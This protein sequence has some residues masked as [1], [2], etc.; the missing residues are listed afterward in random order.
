VIT[1]VSDE[2]KIGLAEKLGASHVINRTTQDIATEIMNITGNGVDAVIDHVGASTWMT[3]LK[4]LK[5]GG[6]MAVCGATSG[7]VANIEVR[8]VYNKQAWI[9][10][11]YL[12]TK[13][14]LGEMMRFMQTK[15]IRPVIDSKIDLRMTARAH[16][17]M[18][19]NMHFGKIVLT[20]H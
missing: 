12:G 1:T 5:L 6:K 14:E 9:I 17:R 19:N 2:A 16:E 20:V 8:T 18:E 11:A 10:G 7:E 4:C 13:K 15:K 3:S